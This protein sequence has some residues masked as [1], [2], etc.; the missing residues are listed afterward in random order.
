MRMVRMLAVLALALAPAIAP[1]QR[2][3][4][5]DRVERVRFA[6]GASAQTVQGRIRGYQTVTYVVGARAGQ[7]MD[8]RLQSRSR[9]LYV[10]VRRPGSDENIHDG[11]LQGN[12]GQVRLPA[13]GD[14]RVR[15]FL[16]RNAARR[17]ETGDY[18]LRISIN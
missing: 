6:P 18:R 9:F 3:A 15:V 2:Q 10:L 7:V 13:T 17:N 14:Y 1:A 4:S 16:F 11:A 8:L 5:G 12:D